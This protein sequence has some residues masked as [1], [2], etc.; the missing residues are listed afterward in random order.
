MFL[1]QTLSA[2]CWVTNILTLKLK[3][4]FSFEKAT[5]SK[6]LCIELIKCLKM[7]TSLSYLQNEAQRE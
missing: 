7:D 6:E 5:A 4:D 3:K 1:T 2:G